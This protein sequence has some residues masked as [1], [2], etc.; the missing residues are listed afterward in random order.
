MA[1]IDD[2]VA[3]AKYPGAHWVYNK[4]TLAEK[5]EYVC[6]PAGIKNSAS[7]NILYDQQ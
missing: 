7:V 3:Y 4:L 6:G 5:L 2:D 1:W